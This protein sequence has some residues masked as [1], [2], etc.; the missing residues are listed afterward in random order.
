MILLNFSHPLTP[1]HLAEIERQAQ[2]PIE[3]VIDV[4]TQF[5][6]TR[7]FAEQARAIVDGIGLSSSEWQSLP[8]LINLPSFSP[9]AALVTA[10]L[11]GRMGYFPAVLRLRPVAASSPGQFEVAEI[12]NLQSVRDLAR[13]NR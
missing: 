5:D 9:I 12:L 3:R 6:H 4:K 11:H 10:E 8:L 2:K 1:V 13:T 7:P